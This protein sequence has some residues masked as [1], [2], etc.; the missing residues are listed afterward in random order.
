MI[1]LLDVNVLVALF[2]P[3]HLHHRAAHLWLADNKRS[4]WATCP[5][6]ENGFCRV[7][8]HPRYPGR[9]TSP[10]DAIARLRQFRGSGHHEFWPDSLSVCDEEHFAHDHLLGHRQITDTYLLALAVAHGARLVTFDQGITP[11]VLREAGPGHLE[12]LTPDS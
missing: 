1:S 2:D 3:A 4:G 6:T 5:I 9:R 8:S 7:I 11:A 12:I 10:S